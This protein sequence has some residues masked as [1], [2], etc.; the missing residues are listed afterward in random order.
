[1]FGIDQSSIVHLSGDAG[2]L[3]LPLALFEMAVCVRLGVSS[4]VFLTKHPWVTMVHCSI[5]R[6][7]EIVFCKPRLCL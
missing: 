1:M 4:E 3:Q 7:F 6:C 5:K 2:A